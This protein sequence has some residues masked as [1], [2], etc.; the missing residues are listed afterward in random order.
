MWLVIIPL[1]KLNTFP[2]QSSTSQLSCPEGIDST[3]RRQKNNISRQVVIKPFPHTNR[4]R[5]ILAFVYETTRNTILLDGGLFHRR[6]PSPLPPGWICWRPVGTSSR[7]IRPTSHG[8]CGWYLC[9]R[10]AWAVNTTTVV[11][12]ASGNILHDSIICLERS[13]HSAV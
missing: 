12:V 2:N 4:S 9:V 6:I 1:I 7:R 5:Y 11:I 8:S 13:G 10:R 3:S